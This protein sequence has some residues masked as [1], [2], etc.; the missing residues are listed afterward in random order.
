M[1]YMETNKKYELTHESITIDNH[2]LYRI[3]AVR[4]FAGVKKG[5]LGGFVETESNLSHDGNCWV[6]ENAQVFTNAQVYDDA[7]GI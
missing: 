1:A 2:T 4:N 6:S 5:D 7:W 3:Q